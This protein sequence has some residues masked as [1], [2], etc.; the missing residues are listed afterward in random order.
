MP[1]NKFVCNF[2]NDFAGVYNEN[3]T[4]SFWDTAGG[5]KDGAAG[6]EVTE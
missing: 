2:A 4:F 1:L 5:D 3:D 6:E